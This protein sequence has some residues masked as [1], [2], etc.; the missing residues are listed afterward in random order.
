MPKKSKVKMKIKTLIYFL[1]FISFSCYGKRI[2]TID[3]NDFVKQFNDSITLR[4]IYCFNEKGEKVWLHFNENS[5]LTIKLSDNKEYKLMLHTIKYKNGKIEAIEYNIWSPSKKISTFDINSVTSFKIERMFYEYDSPYFDIDDIKKTVLFKN[6]SIK[7]K[8]SKGSEFV[9]TLRKKNE[10]NGK[11]Q[12]LENVSYNIKFRDNKK[13]EY[14]VVQKISKDSIYISND[15]NQNMSLANKRTY[16]IYKYPISEITELELLKSGG[17]S[18]KTVKIEEFEVN[19]D[20]TNSDTLHIPSWF[21]MNPTT[22]A[23]NFYR[24]WLTDRGFLGI[25]EN[26]QKI[27]WYEGE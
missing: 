22:G 1:I 10:L 20:K 2:Y 18:L 3:K 4:K 6:D 27:F 24:S 9:I 17:W 11:L 13:T 5:Q 15:Y 21:A 14:G 25:T 23:I 8:Y 7:V 12:I 26:N 19:V 16:E